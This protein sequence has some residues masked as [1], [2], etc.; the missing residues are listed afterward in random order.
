MDTTKAAA[1]RMLDEYYQIY[2]LHLP[3]ERKKSQWLAENKRGFFLGIIQEGE[4][5]HIVQIHNLLATSQ[6]TEQQ[7]LSTNSR[8]TQHPR[9]FID[10][11]FARYILPFNKDY[12]DSSSCN[13]LLTLKEPSR[14]N[15]ADD[16]DYVPD[17]RKLPHNDLKKALGERDEACLFCWNK[18]NVKTSHIIAQKDIPIV[19]K[20]QSVLER[21]GLT[22]KHQVQNGLLL[23]S[24]C[25][26]DFDRLQ[27]YVDVV[28]EKLVVKLINNSAL[29][30]DHKHTEWE[31][32]VRDLKG[33]RRLREEDWTDRQAVEPN[34]EVALY[35]VRNNA[36]KLPNRAALKFHKAACLIW[37]MSGG[38]ESEDEHSS[39]DDHEGHVSVDYRTKGIE[40]WM[41]SSATLK[42]FNKVV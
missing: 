24:N 19:F 37:R 8:D 30:N 14:S 28:D 7:I 42:M 11:L 32:A 15:S 5:S 41:D 13:T 1:R 18:K 26:D 40:K 4:D 6:F 33:A 31:R 38:A 34:G 16:M 39:N 29:P 25:H 17:E 20:E 22:Q 10:D 21:A 2:P 36:T 3:T 12:S 9:T 23:C 27:R 35:F